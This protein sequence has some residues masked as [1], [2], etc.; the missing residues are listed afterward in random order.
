MTASTTH[1]STPQR[2]AVAGAS[3]RMGHMLIEAILNSSDCVLA[4]ALDRAT[5]LPSA[6]ILLH[7]WVSPAG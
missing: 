5:A 1:S 7:S 6:P 3:G 2:V 4:A